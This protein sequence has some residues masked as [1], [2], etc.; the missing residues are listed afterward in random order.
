MVVQRLPERPR[1]GED[2][3]GHQGKKW[4]LELVIVDNAASPNIPVAGSVEAI[5]YG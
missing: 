3:H 4:P 5:A 1:S 2:L